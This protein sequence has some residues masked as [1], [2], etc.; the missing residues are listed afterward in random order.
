MSRWCEWDQKMTSKIIIFIISYTIYFKFCSALQDRNDQKYT[1]NN[2]K[3]DVTK[4]LSTINAIDC[5]LNKGKC[6]E[7]SFNDDK[8]NCC[9]TCIVRKCE[10]LKVTKCLL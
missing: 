1:Q 3:C 7:K 5:H 6:I 8:C 9:S 2:C 10:F 4:C